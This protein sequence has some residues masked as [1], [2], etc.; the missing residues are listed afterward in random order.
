MTGSVFLWSPGWIIAG[1]GPA[2]ISSTGSLR[3]NVGAK[4]TS[5]QYLSPPPESTKVVS[6]TSRALFAHTRNKLS[7]KA[8]AVPAM[9]RTTPANQRQLTTTDGTDGDFEVRSSVA[10]GALFANARKAGR[11]AACRREP[12]TIFDSQWPA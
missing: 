2:P 1:E 3:S 9:L 11:S 10:K 5:R 6:S 7:I 12:Q 8:A 4:R